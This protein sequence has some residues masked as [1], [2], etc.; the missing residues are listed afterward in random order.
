[1]TVPRKTFLVGS[2]WLLS[3]V[4]AG[5]IGAK[6]SPDRA[7]SAARGRENLAAP[8]SLTKAA[9]T[10]ARPE[11]GNRPSKERPGQSDWSREI[12]DLLRMPGGPGRTE[13]LLR[14]LA[15]VHPSEFS[16]VVD[17][18]RDDPLSPHHREHYDLILAAWVDLDPFAAAEYLERSD[19]DG[20]ARET[21]LAAWA[22]RDPVSARMWAKGR[23]DDGQTNNWVVGLARGMAT[24]DSRA[25][26]SLIEDL[27]PGPTQQASIQAVAPHLADESP[28][29]AR[30]WL[31]SLAPDDPLL[32]QAARATAKELAR[33]ETFA[34]ADWAAQ[35][36]HPESRCEATRQVARVWVAEDPSRAMAWAGEL[37][38]ETLP[39]AAEGITRQLARDAPQRVADWL[40]TLDETS[41]LDGARR[42]FLGTVQSSHPALA[43]DTVPTLSDRDLQERYYSS[44]LQ[45]WSRQDAVAAS[46]WAHENADLLPGELR[47]RFAREHQ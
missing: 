9:P 43:L 1:M 22:E 27:E 20:R 21:V 25:A 45:R 18:F 32:P 42:T 11:S 39:S 2:A 47:Q 34:A 10:G 3:L 15:K 17:A 28:E 24:G 13:A 8:D 4:A 6:L 5:V 33:H 41:A 38:G 19:T 31:D 7:G 16:L 26:L 14:L 37:P 44:I 46:S 12:A 29:L 40:H 23:P 30:A 36:N 35:L